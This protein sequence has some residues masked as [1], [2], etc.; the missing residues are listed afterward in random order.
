LHWWPHAQSGARLVFKSDSVTVPQ[1]HSTPTSVPK[2]RGLLPKSSLVR[3]EQKAPHL[4]LVM[5]LA[6]RSAPGKMRTFES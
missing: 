1:W 5:L 3:D 2:C 4:S 6:D